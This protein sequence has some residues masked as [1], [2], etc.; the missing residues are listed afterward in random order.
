M[1][2][3]QLGVKTVVAPAGKK[4]PTGV[5]APVVEALRISA[6]GFIQGVGLARFYIHHP[7]IGLGMPD[8]EATV[9]ANGIEH[10]TAIV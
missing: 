9:I 1:G 3:I 6:I 5:Q 2:E 10:E 8:G 7:K 4:Y